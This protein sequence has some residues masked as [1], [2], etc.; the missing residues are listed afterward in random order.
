MGREEE[1]KWDA[2]MVGALMKS[3]TVED[4]AGATGRMF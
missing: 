2:T 1:K 4:A 3:L